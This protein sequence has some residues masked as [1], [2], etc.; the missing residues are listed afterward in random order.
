MGFLSFMGFV[1]HPLTPLQEPSM[2]PVILLLIAATVALAAAVPDHTTVTKHLKAI[3]VEGNGGFGFPMWAPVVDRDGLVVVMTRSGEHRGDQWPGSRAISAQKA[4]TA[5]AFSL[6]G[7]A[8][9]T[10]NLYYAVQPGGS[11]YGLQHSNPLDTTVIYGGEAVDFGT[12]KDPMIGKRV[13]GVN[14]SAGAC[15]SMTRPVPSSV[16]LA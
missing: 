14:A 8:I 4:N 16:R 13:G 7:L 12:A 9:S 1:A 15:R 11:L 5:N 6:P 3:V 10:A 2:R